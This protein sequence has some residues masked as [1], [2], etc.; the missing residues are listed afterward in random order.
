MGEKWSKAVEDWERVLG[1]DSALLG[2]S[3][4]AT[5]TLASDGI[6][7]SKKMIEGGNSQ[8]S[9]SAPKPKSKPAFKP[10]PI[11]SS[12]PEPPS[13]AVLALRKANAAAEA[14]EEA[15]ADAK[16][17]VDAKI[18]A[19]KGGKET[20]IRALISS[21]DMVLW[22]EILAGGLKVGMHEVITEKQVKIKYM[23]V[24]ARLHPDKVCL[25]PFSA[26]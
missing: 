5:K 25:C 8:S 7:R 12:G 14:E 3:G 6:R 24:I 22:D 10:K 19:W 13:E 26:K 2:P 1:F 23:K 4:A 9:A 15:K 20:N 11:P 18:N 16:A 21:L 17:G